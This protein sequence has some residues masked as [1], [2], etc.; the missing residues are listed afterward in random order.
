MSS[1]RKPTPDTPSPRGRRLTSEVFGLALLFWAAFLL[2][3]LLTYNPLDPS[4]NHVVSNAAEIHNEA[5]RFGAYVSGLL[6]DLF[7]CAAMIWPLAF[8]GWGVGCVSTS[9]SMPW[10]RWVGFLLLGGCLITLG[11]AWNVG[12]A[13]VRGGGML[14]TQLYQ[15]AVVLTGHHGASL[16]WLYVCFL[17]LELCFGISWYDLL[18]GAWKRFADWAAGKGLMPK[19]PL[20][21]LKNWWENR[22]RKPAE[23]PVIPLLHVED[24]SGDLNP[25]P[26]YADLSRPADAPQQAAPHKRKK[27]ARQDNAPSWLPWSAPGTDTPGPGHT[28][29]AEEPART[30][31]APSLRSR[32]AACVPW[33][34]QKSVQARQDA[35][36]QTI[37]VPTP[38]QPDASIPPIRRAQPVDLRAGARKAATLTDHRD[39]TAPFPPSG[40]DAQDAP[41]SMGATPDQDTANKGLLQSFLR[42]VRHDDANDASAMPLPADPAAD[43]ASSGASEI[44]LQQV[45]DAGQASSGQERSFTAADAGAPAAHDNAM[46]TPQA[47]PVILSGLGQTTAERPKTVQAAPVAQPP[48]QPVQLDLSSSEAS[49]PS[50]RAYRLPPLSLLEQAGN[51]AAP[52]S[53]EAMEAK[54]DLLMQCLANFN[55]NAELVQ[56][57]P[58]PVVTLFELRPAPGTKVARIR[59]L[60]EDIKLSLRAL[61]VRIETIPGAD[62]VG[63]EIPNE[64]RS[65]V[66]FRSI[67]ASS[68]FQQ[69]SSL[70]T[71]GMGVSIGGEPTVAELGKMPHLL[72]GGATGSGKSVGVN[73]FLLSLLYKATPDELQLL[74]ID[75]KRV[76]FALYADLP[77]LIHPVVNE[78]AI[79]KN[80]LEW[81]VHEMEQRYSLLQRA[82]VRNFAGYNQKIREWGD[83]RPAGLE[84]LAPLPY[85]VIVVDELADLMMCAGKDVEAAIV[86]L[87]QL[88]RA[89]GIHLIIATQRPSVDV[90]TGLIKANFPSRV[91]FLV[92]NGHD[93]RTI[94]DESGAEDLLGMG[95]MLFRPNGGKPRRLHGPFVPDS[96][97]Q[98]VVEFWKS[99]KKAEYTLD[100]SEWGAPSA[101]TKKSADTSGMSEEDALYAQIIQFTLE[102][103][104]GI[105]ISK[106]Q[107]Q[108][109]IGF[110]KAARFMEQM[111]KDGIIAPPGHAN[112]ARDIISD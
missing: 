50:R 74:L 24:D 46:Q 15:Q 97:V 60:K 17:A 5:G 11:A 71:L 19:A 47:R 110:N 31:A 4:L 104:K 92:S 3:A 62:T 93:S 58:G 73:A 43:A 12:I 106:L 75:P 26:G 45:V 101:D 10:W 78:P 38:A 22:H 30:Q 79:A 9:I 96:D 44:L 34:G 51:D 89:A 37:P 55:I 28:S 33:L 91:A 108:F 69:A 76:E 85:L 63:V 94:L 36:R 68:A 49:A 84:D 99:Q 98:A 100:F 109:R 105:S 25:L 14:G 35:P 81:A 20:Q 6:V 41:L 111:Q 16:L 54:G 2:L 66:N 7:G 103:G 86:R 64:H 59:N 23:P 8:I 32:F 27:S 80:A 29:V 18:H 90:V 107:R 40:R 102:Q 112:R 95:D 87:A 83:Q 48:S 13:H 53:P 42:R 57:T 67:L 1:R 82:G 52:P 39:L 70:L 88:A 65:T 56:I 61:S 72:V 21:P 77:H